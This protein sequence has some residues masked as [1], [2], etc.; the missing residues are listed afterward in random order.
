[1]A[2]LVAEGA[3]EADIQTLTVRYDSIKLDK[4]EDIVNTLQGQLQDQFDK[5]PATISMTIR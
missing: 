4:P 3:T 5:T 1:M 2:S